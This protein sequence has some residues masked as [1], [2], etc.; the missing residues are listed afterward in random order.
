MLSTFVGSNDFLIVLSL[1]IIEILCIILNNYVLKHF[2]VSKLL[3]G[4]TTVKSK[5]LWDNSVKIKIW[6]CFKHSH[7]SLNMAP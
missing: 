1:L 5:N 3:A 6:R 7:L 4:I 2:T